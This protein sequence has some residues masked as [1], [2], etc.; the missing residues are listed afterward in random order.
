VSSRSATSW[1]LSGSAL[2]TT[3][4]RPNELE[5]ASSMAYAASATL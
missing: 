4:P 2:N 3:P 1:A 5:L